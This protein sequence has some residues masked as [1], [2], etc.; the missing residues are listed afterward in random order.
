MLKLRPASLAPIHILYKSNVVV[1]HSYSHTPR[2]YVFCFN[3]L[4]L[5]LVSV[6]SGQTHNKIVT[7]HVYQRISMLSINLLYP[8]LVRDLGVVGDELP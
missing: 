8:L 7:Q 3:S 2:L 6:I 4:Q 5:L 1:E